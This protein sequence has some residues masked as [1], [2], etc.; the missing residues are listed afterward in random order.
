MFLIDAIKLKIENKFKTCFIS[1]RVKF[2]SDNK[3]IIYKKREYN[4]LSK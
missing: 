3:N 1:F 2:A 4:F